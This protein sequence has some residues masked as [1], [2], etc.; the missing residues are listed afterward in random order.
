MPG[1]SA[2]TFVA[3]TPPMDSAPLS[4]T[5]TSS[6]SPTATRVELSHSVPT[7]IPTN[8]FLP[9]GVQSQTSASRPATTHATPK[10]TNLPSRARSLSGASLRARG[11][12]LGHKMARSPTLLRQQQDPLVSPM[13]TTSFQFP[14]TPSVHHVPESDGASPMMSSVQ[15]PITAQSAFFNHDDIDAAMN[16]SQGGYGGMGGHHRSATDPM[17]SKTYSTRQQNSFS[18]FPASSTDLSEGYHRASASSSGLS[19]PVD[20]SLY[21]HHSHSSS[22]GQLPIMSA[23]PPHQYPAASSNVDPSQAPDSSLSYQLQMTTPGSQRSRL[24]T[25]SYPTSAGAPFTP[26]GQAHRPSH[27]GASLWQPNFTP[28]VEQGTPTRPSSHQATPMMMDHDAHRSSMAMGVRQGEMDQRV[29]S[30]NPPTVPVPVS[31]PLEGDWANFPLSQSGDMGQLGHADPFM[32][33]P[34]QPPN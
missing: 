26:S 21:R 9:A 33:Y 2:M 29:L 10:S 20:M 32:V 22:F 18:G 27:S 30:P 31:F 4:T 8:S 14:N 6:S 15:T 25:Q 13:S 5:S 12:T 19:S 28:I 23:P 17:G 16:A 1:T 34:N 24:H 3:T 11:L 7:F